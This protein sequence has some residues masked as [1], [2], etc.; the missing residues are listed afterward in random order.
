MM[1]NLTWPIG[2]TTTVDSFIRAP[3]Y[4]FINIQAASMRFAAVIGALIGFFLGSLFNEYLSKTR[5]HQHSWRPEYRLFGVFIPAVFECA[6]LLLFGFGNQFKLSWVA[7]A[8]GWC[9]VNIGLVG[10]VVAITAFVLEKYPAHA[11]TVSAIM[12]MWRSCGKSL[13]IDEFLI[14]FSIY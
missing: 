9:M 11:T 4:L 3:P 14:A 10:T 7:L 1:I 5:I 8:F 2:I 13:R 12:N 6:G